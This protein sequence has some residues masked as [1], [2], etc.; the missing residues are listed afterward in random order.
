MAKLQYRKE[1]KT[2]NIIKH[3]V[4]WVPFD[5]MTICVKQAHKIAASLALYYYSFFILILTISTVSIG[6]YG[7]KKNCGQVTKTTDYVIYKQ[8]WTEEM[9]RH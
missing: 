8:I 4:V 7:Y 1:T 2:K 6:E 3:N 5:L 9:N